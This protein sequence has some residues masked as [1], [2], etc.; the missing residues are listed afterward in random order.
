MKKLFIC[1]ILLFMFALNAECTVSSTDNKII[2]VGDDT[3]T[4]FP[5]NFKIFDD[6]DLVVTLQVIATGAETTQTITT[7]YTVS[8]AGEASGGN[9]T[10]I[11][12]PE[13]TENLIIKRVLPLTQGTDLVDNTAFSLEVLETGFDKLV[14]MIQELDE[15]VS[16]S[17]LSDIGGTTDYTF[18]TPSAGLA[19]KW[20]PAEDGLIN[21]TYDPDTLADEAAASAAA[22]AASEATVANLSASATASAA[23]AAASAASVNLPSSLAG[24]SG[25]ALVVK[26]DETGYEHVYAATSVGAGL[27]MTLGEIK[28]DS[29]DIARTMLEADI[30][31]GTKIEDDVVDSEHFVAGSIDG[32]HLSAGMVI[33]TEYTQTGSVNTGTTVLP[34]DNTIPQNTEGDEYMTVSIIPES[35]TNILEI[36][37]VAIASFSGAAHLSSAL[38]QD[39]TADA[40]AGMVKYVP[41]NNQPRNLGFIHTMAAGTTSETT[42]KLRIGGSGAGTTTFNGGDGSGRQGGKLASSMIVT[43]RK[44]T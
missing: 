6:T 34:Y 17:I 4:I 25:K 30:I 33:K 10:M 16:R 23:A 21:S 19:L 3:T 42:F 31:D 1:L 11:T 26:G 32:E 28:I 2:Y 14:M 20:N 24:D 5:Y 12:A 40:L 29:G 39:S 27:T 41:N 8:G 9:V 18:P 22:A 7:D 38:F 43:E 15:R 44:A 37:I 35:A 13:D 36:N